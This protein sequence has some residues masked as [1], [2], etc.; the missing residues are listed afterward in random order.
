MY[1][2]PRYKACRKGNE[3]KS[4]FRSVCDTVG[5]AWPSTWTSGV[6]SDTNLTEPLVDSN[7]DSGDASND[8]I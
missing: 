3:D 8:I 4:R 1:F 5:I 6:N 7:N 2:Y